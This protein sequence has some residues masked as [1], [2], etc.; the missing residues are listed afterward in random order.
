MEDELVCLDTSIL[1]DYFRKSKKENSFF[2]QL[3][4]TYSKFS[5][6]VITEYEIYTGSNSIQDKFWDQ[7]FSKVISLP[8]DQLVL[9]KA[10]EI[11]REL[12]SAGNMIDIPDLF[13]GVTALVNELPLATLNP[14]HFS[15]IKELKLITI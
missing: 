4:Q 3:L 12:R 10:I 14:K 13:I 2:F 8:F 11:S 5:T 6:S 9:K 15:R 7:F 1:I